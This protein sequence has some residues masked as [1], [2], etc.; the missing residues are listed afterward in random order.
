M[1]K[2]FY[3]FRQALI[4]SVEKVAELAVA[5]KWLRRIFDFAKPICVAYHFNSAKKKSE[6]KQNFRS[7]KNQN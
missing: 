1:L 4:Q 7:R 2:I 6:Q 3:K 5:R